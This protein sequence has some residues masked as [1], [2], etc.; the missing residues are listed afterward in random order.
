MDLAKAEGTEGE[1][2]VNGR[3]VEI[4]VVLLEVCGDGHV[5]PAIIQRNERYRAPP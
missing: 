1:L 2:W 4:G 3:N 5:L